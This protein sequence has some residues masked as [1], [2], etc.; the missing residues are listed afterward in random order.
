M[1]ILINNLRDI[2]KTAK[3]AG[4]RESGEERKE[5]MTGI[6]ASVIPVTITRTVFSWIP[7]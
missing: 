1:K 7:T 5:V 4:D 2:A 6:Y 3:E